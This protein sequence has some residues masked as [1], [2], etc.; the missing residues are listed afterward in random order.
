MMDYNVDLKSL[1]EVDENKLVKQILERD[2]CIN[3][4]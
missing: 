1:L 3:K 2:S 4:I